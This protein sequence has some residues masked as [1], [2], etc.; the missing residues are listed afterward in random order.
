MKAYFLF[1]DKIFIPLIT[2]LFRFAAIFNRKVKT[3]VKGRK[4]LESD[5]SSIKSALE[6]KYTDSKLIL[7]HSVSMGEYEQAKPLIKLI[8]RD[9]PG[10]AVG[11]SFFSPT[12]MEFY[13]P[14]EEIDFVCYSPVDKYKKC[15]TFFEILEP[16]ILVIV[17]H[18]IWPNMIKAAYDKNV[19]LIM[20][21]ATLP[22]HSKRM[23]FY[24]KKFY[25]YIYSL[26]DYIFPISEHDDERIR[27]IG[28]EIRK[29]IVAGDTRFDQVVAR[30]LKA[31]EN[32]GKKIFPEKYR[33]VII[34][35]SVWKS[36]TD[37]ILQ[38]FLKVMS[39]FED[40]AAIIC[41]HEPEEDY[42]ESIEE[43]LNKNGLDFVRY[44]KL[45]EDRKTDR[46]IILVDTVGV[47][48]ELYAYADI[49]FVGGSFVP[50]VHNVMEPGIMGI[51][52]LFG[53]KHE[54]SFEAIQMVHLGGAYSVENDDDLYK[55]MSLVLE[56][57]NIREKMGSV[58]YEY[59]NRNIGAAAKIYENIRELL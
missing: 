20:I 27:D 29:S 9:Y 8:K 46:R 37:N 33:N 21:D 28:S 34:L 2:F 52:V 25:A 56:N 14:M 53:P 39:E 55:K 24:A 35:G 3:G 26:F 6:Q 40:T 30:G 10:Y 15:R 48:A 45:P 11:I 44:T 19:K 16:D 31:R 7:F 49:A 43:E 47:L 17:K 5:L 32:R 23:S 13:K 57:G 41:P 12:G 1:Y 18:D 4:T 38:G 51:P 58:A 42:L 22:P 54:N 36:D 50:G 59:V